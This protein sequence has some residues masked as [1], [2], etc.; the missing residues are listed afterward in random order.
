MLSILDNP[1]WNA[2]STGSASHALG[3]QRVKYMQRDKGIFVGFKTYHRDEW[4]DL[5]TWLPEQ[6]QVILFAS[7]KVD[8]PTIW[9]IKAHRPLLQMV[10]E[11]TDIPVPTENPM[12]T[13]L[14]H[15]DIPAMLDLTALTNPGPFFNKTIELGYYE[16]I[17]VQERLVAMAGQRLHPDPYVEIS[18]V[19][20]DPD[21][22]GK[23]MAAELVRNQVR[24]ILSES[25]VPFL[26]VNTDNYGAIKL[27]E[28]TGFRPRKEIWVYF[29][30]M[31]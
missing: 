1:I 2:L 22:V 16:G 27:Y 11:S 14:F 8:I 31:G 29:L 25:K 5:E 9:K 23:G 15:R 10:Y 18:A 26:H 7:E 20:T 30:E 21:F 28:K 13:P 6:S 19:C 24:R 12:A 17:F 4:R 3:N